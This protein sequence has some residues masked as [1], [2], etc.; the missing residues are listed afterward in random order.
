MPE[1]TQAQTQVPSAESTGSV[2][3]FVSHE[4]PVADA[5][6][7]KGPTPGP[8]IP[9]EPEK[10]LAESYVEKVAP[11]DLPKIKDV[12]VIPDEVGSSK[13]RESL[14]EDLKNNKTLE[15]FKTV[16]DLARSLVNAQQLLGK[17][18]AKVLVPDP[19]VATD[20]DYREVFK[21]LGLPEDPKEYKVELPSDAGLD[22]AFLEK[23][24][25]EAHKMGVLPKQLEKLLGWY[26]G[27][28]KE[29]FKAQH[30]QA[31]QAHQASHK[32][33]QAE[34]GKAY[35]KNVLAAQLA[36][37][38]VATPE[39]IKYLADRG[40]TT[41]TTLIR[42]FSKLGNM[43][44]EGEL[45]GSNRG[46]HDS[47]TPADA[48]AQAHRIMGDANHPYNKADHVNHAMAV[49]EVER[50]MAMAHPEPEKD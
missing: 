39:Q 24:K 27:E 43:L 34:W 9:G 16:E 7:G 41:D 49:K 6:P 8:E 47:L 26:S 14:P 28:S 18:S 11:K 19:K 22:P 12:P 50:L 36:V 17:E 4:T 5:T 38:D 21:K 33:L 3:S 31:Q 32:E 23:I 37:K 13:W 20:A 1:A 30:M 15:R 48:Q 42:I 2:A 44:K 29:A 46:G 10:P 35:D 25:V 45:K 40:L